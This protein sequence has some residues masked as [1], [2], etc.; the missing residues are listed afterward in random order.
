LPVSSEYALNPAAGVLAY[1][2]YPAMFDV[3]SVKRFENTGAQVT[4]F[5][6]DLNSQTVQAVATS[7]ARPL[8]PI[9]LDDNKLEYDS[10]DGEGRLVTD[11]TAHAAPPPTAEPSRIQFSPGATSAQVTGSLPAGG[12]HHYVLNAMA[13]QT[14]YVRFVPPPIAEPDA[15]LIIW[16]ADGTVLISSHADATAWEGPLPSTQDYYIS[17]RSHAERA[18]DYTL[19]VIIPVAQLAIKMF[20]ADIEDIPSGKRLTF[21]WET[22]G[23]SEARIWSGTRLRFPDAWDVP[24]NGTLTVELTGGTTRSNPSMTLVAS[25]ELGNSVDQSVTVLWECTYQDAFR[26]DSGICHAKPT[27]TVGAEQLFESGRM[28]W[29]QELHLS[30][31]SSMQN[32]IFVLYGAGDWEQFDDTWTSDQPESDPTLIPPEGLHQ[33]VRGFGKLWRGNDGVRQRLGWG[34]APEAA[35]EAVWQRQMTQAG[36]E[37]AYMRT[38]DGQTIELVGSR[39]GTWRFVTP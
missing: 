15:I 29:L 27:F 18:T 6:Y 28:M 5:V 7:I 34:L 31:A 36:P 1:S 32:V 19:E 13:G 23:A 10:P 37:I 12:A 4:L 17:V 20:T 21:Y 26:P 2:D 25:D 35:F 11:V 22:T 39:S 16:G 8:N 3:E 30:E 38:S 24:L 9:W 14:M 33:P